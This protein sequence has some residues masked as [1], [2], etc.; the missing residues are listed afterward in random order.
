MRHPQPELVKNYYAKVDA[1]LD[2]K[3]PKCCHTCDD[4]MENGLC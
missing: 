2:I 3:E 4:Y 1:L